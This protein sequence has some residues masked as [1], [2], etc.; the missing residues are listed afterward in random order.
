MTW[1]I[2]GGAGYIGAHVL[3]AFVA[4]GMPV[5]V[6]DDLSTG[7]RERV[8]EAAPFVQGSIL[9]VDLLDAVLVDHAVTGVVHVAG[10]KSVPES[11]ARPEFYARQNVDGTRVLLAACVRH[12]VR[13]FVFSSSAAVYGVIESMQPITEDAPVVPI[14][15]YGQSKLDAERLVEK[16]TTDGAIEA[17]AFRY[18]NVGGAKEPILEDTIGENLIPIVRRAIAAGKPVR[19]FG[20]DLPTRD[21]TCIRD[22]IHVEDLAAA[23]LAAARYLEGA[24]RA[25][26]EVVNLGTGQG[27]TVLEVLDAISRAEGV[28]V[29]WEPALP[30]PGDPAASTCD[31]S[32][33]GDLLG[34]R[35]EHGLDDI[36]APGWRTSKPR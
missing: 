17:I 32:K 31:A 28:P 1:L 16:A 2:T 21:G 20:T 10:K 18:F 23:H 24:P 13:H 26:F 35:A 30:R 33:A 19:V 27:S 29:P 15:P 6:L 7:V 3:R 4:A 11:I 25:G 5:V 34:W 8:P 12:G 9:D 36:V 14:N 22:Y